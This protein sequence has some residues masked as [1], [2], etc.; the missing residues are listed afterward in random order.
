MKLDDVG[1]ERPS[2]RMELVDE[3]RRLL[4]IRP[5]RGVAGEEGV[6]YEKVVV[7][8]QDGLPVKGGRSRGFTCE[9]ESLLQREG[10]IAYDMG[11]CW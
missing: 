1:E 7:K 10:V 3:I 2:V 9:N 4:G 11:R 5:L 6:I 8:E